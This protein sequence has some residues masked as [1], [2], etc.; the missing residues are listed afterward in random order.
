MKAFPNPFRPGAGQLPPTLAG[1]QKEIDLFTNEIL[2]QAPVLKNLVITGLKGV[3]KTVL[4]DTIK[5]VALK[6][7]WSWGGADLSESIDTEEK[8]AL[9]IITDLAAAM[10]IKSIA[11]KSEY[12][13]HFLSLLQVYV[14]SPGL[15]NDK[16][17]AVCEH[18]WELIKSQAKGIVLAYDE[19]QN[20]NDGKGERP[21]TLLLEV[22]QYLQKKQ[23]PFIL[24]LTGLPNLYKSY[25]KQELHIKQDKVNTRLQFPCFTAL[26]IGKLKAKII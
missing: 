12:Q 19:A 16:L 4:L 9:R 14:G 3:G 10:P 2:T 1:R 8:I 23:L 11:Q 26:L 18:A 21:L 13:N 7:G 6:S 15:Q 5:P 17:K 22:F 25:V 24:I 20:L